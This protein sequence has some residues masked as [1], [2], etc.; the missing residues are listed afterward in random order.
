[1]IFAMTFTTHHSSS[2]GNLYTVDHGNHR[3]L[4]EAGVPVR[5]VREATKHGLSGY[6]ACLISHSH[7]DHSQS[8]AEIM[9]AGIDLFC[10]QETATELGLSGHR[11]N[12]IEPL[13][14][15]QVGGF[16]IMGFPLEH[17]VMNLG[18]LMG[19][20]NEKL[21]YITDTA[22]CRYTLYGLT[23]ICIECNWSKLTLAP[24]LDPTV[25]RRLYRSHM[26]LEAVKKFL[27]ANDLRRV[28]EIH[29]LHV[30]DGNGDPEYFRGEIVKQTGKITY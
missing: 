30:S 7:G 6:D 28:V 14:Q 18:F 2:S 27:A 20:G 25:K 23:H 26:S 13:K 11:L 12:I 16:S 1:M 15:F 3:L 24:N 4:I 17:D 19:A 22:Y 9:R 21:T 29:L 10:A 5:K 8:A